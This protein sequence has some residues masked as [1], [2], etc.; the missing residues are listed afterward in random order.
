MQRIV[1]NDRTSKSV[2]KRRIAR[3]ESSGSPQPGDRNQDYRSPEYSFTGGPDRVRGRISQQ[4]IND[5]RRHRNSPNRS[6]RESGGSSEHNKR[7]IDLT[8]ELTD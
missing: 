4:M 5:E 8:Q 7:M 6:I 1:F 2:P 3:Q